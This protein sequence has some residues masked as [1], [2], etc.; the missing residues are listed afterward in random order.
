MD[1]QNDNTVEIRDDTHTTIDTGKIM[2][3]KKVF[4]S[5]MGP[6][7]IALAKA[8]SKKEREELNLKRNATLTYGE[9]D[10]T[11]FAVTIEKIIN[12]YG[13]P[14]VGASGPLGI[15][16]SNGGLFYDLGAGTGKPVIAA[17]TLHPFDFCTG[18]ELLEGLHT[19][20]MEAVF[21]YNSKGRAVGLD[22]QCQM[23]KGDFR[24]FN[25]K[26]WTDG[27]IV[28]ANSTCYDDGIM[29]SI[30]NLGRKLKRGAFVVTISRRLP[31]IEFEV[32]E[33]E[34]HKMSWGDATIFIH[35]KVTEAVI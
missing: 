10:Y 33:N 13:K 18:I 2:S 32:I 30:A 29:D 15:L 14:D 35:Q 34:L 21:S 28:F 24:D 12:M 4:D 22:T 23:I 16:Q 9:I 19:L 8:A 20:S 7:T 26:D 25:V 1:E 11:T 5:I 3:R 27:D 17:A 31:S 6:Y